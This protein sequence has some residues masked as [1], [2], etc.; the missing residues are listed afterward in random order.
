MYGG[1]GA[2]TG[3]LAAGNTLD[4]THDLG[5]FMSQS[6]YETTVDASDHTIGWSTLAIEDLAFV[7]VAISEV[8]GG[9]PQTVNPAGR[10]SASSYGAV[11]ALA[12]NKNVAVTGRTSASS[13][14]SVTPVAGAVSVAVAGRTSQSTYGTI[15][16]S[17]TGPQ[18]VAVTGRTSA[19][20]FG[21]LTVS[22]GPVTVAVT[23]RSSAS[24]YGAVGVVVGGVVIQVPGLTS[25]SQ[26]GGVQIEGQENGGDPHISCVQVQTCCLHY[27]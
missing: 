22:P 6:C 1:A 2:P 15:T 26:F 11:T 19:S 13:F 3:T 18:T 9:A 4:H 21:T 17:G 8:A 25:A 23:G 5:N 12:G 27:Y 10:T 14:G 16:P 24:S 7:A 20:S